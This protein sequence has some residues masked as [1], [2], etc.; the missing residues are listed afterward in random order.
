[1]RTPVDVNRIP[2]L[3]EQP[4]ERDACRRSTLQNF[5]ICNQRLERCRYISIAGRLT[6]RKRACIAAQIWKML[7]NFLRCR[8]KLLPKWVLGHP[9]GPPSGPSAAT[10]GRL[11]Q[12]TPPP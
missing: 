4:I 6:S 2:D 11:F 7:R 5:R 8:Q 3:R 10:E 1:R 9:P 12:Q